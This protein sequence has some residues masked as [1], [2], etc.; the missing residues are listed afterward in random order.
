MESYVVHDRH[1]VETIIKLECPNGS[2]RY[3]T[4][5][6]FGARAEFRRGV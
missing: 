4:V 5:A 1:A 2:E 3:G 6:V